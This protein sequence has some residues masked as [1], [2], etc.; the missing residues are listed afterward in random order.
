LRFL[1]NHFASSP[2]G[3]NPVRVTSLGAL[4]LTTP[5]AQLKRMNDKRPAIPITGDNRALSKLI[6]N[7]PALP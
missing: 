6:C 1:F 4:I 2:L 5:H 7:R 3:Q